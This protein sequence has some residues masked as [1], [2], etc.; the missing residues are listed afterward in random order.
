MK[1]ENGTYAGAQGGQFS[2]GVSRESAGSERLCLHRVFIE[3]RTETRA[4]MHDGHESAIYVLAGRHQIRYG[5]E[6][7]HLADLEPGDMVY[8]PA[9]MLHQPIVGDED[10]TALV[11]R[12]DP[13]EQESLRLHSPAQ[14]ETVGA[15]A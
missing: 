15:S 4:H 8:I 3:A 7:Q 10:V 11:A 2:A 13:A 1:N 12:T 14:A 6:L 5:D 9:G